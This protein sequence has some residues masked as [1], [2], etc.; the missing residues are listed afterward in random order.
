[1]RGEF[2]VIG[3]RINN[4]SGV[5][6][7]ANQLIAN[8]WH[9]KS[10]HKL[11]L[12]SSVYMQDNQYDPRRNAVD[13][14]NQLLWRRP[15]IRLEAECI[16]DSMLSVSGQLDDTMYGPGTLDEAM[17]RRSIYF[18]IKRSRIIPMMLLFDAPNSLTAMGSRAVTTVAPQALAMMNNPQI[19]SYARSLAKKLDGST[20][21]EKVTK[22][23]LLALGRK[24]DAAELNDTISFM[25]DQQQQYTAT[26][27][28]DAAEQVIIDFCQ[29]LLS[30]SEF[31]YVE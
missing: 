8:Q 12:T 21:T 3:Q 14:D 2:D 6:V 11:I 13:P 19:Q 30:L 26:G 25:A 29:S 10:I 24:P 31:I 22:G 23:Y 16:R 9:L 4:Y 28:P 5:G 20:P 15:L 17:K 1:M 18:F 7:R 27:R